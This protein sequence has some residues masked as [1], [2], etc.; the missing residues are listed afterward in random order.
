MSQPL[1]LLTGPLL[2]MPQ[3]GTTLVTGPP[4]EIDLIDSMPVRNIPLYDGLGFVELVD[5]MPRRVPA[6]HTADVAIARN[7][8][9]SYAKDSMP[10]PAET[11]RLVRYLTE[12]WHTSPSESVVFQFRGRVPIFVSRHVDRHRTA[13]A[14]YESGRYIEMPEE[15]YLPALRM[16]SKNNKQGSDS[17]TVPAEALALWNECHAD[18]TAVFA[19]YKRLLALGVAKEVAR[20]ILPQALMTSFMWQMDLHNLLHFLRLRLDSHAQQETREFA[21]GIHQLIAG[22][23]PV[24]MR[25][26]EDF[27]LNQLSFDVAE[28]RYMRDSSNVLGE[29]KKNQLVDKLKRINVTLS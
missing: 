2:I 7:A 14:N 9:V 25:A 17:S 18:M 3:T 15:M 19:K 26:F 12:H 16:Q 4:T 11:E 28:Q 1:D 21:A 10:T 8:R 27:Q 13:R 22:L 20:T 23:V 24:S 29:R 5:M 6:G